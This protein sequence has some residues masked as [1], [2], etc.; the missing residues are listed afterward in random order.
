MCRRKAYGLK[1]SLIIDTHRTFEGLA[2][3]GTWEMWIRPCI[4]DS[5]RVHFHGS[6][7]W[8]TK[9]KENRTDDQ[10]FAWILAMILSL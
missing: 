6:H 8:L 7:Y 3:S 9:V 5:W 1:L 4:A 10:R 2:M